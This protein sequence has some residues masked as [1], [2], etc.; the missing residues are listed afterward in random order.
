VRPASQ[1]S[2]AMPRALPGKM[3]HSQRS[4]AKMRSSSAAIL[5]L[6]TLS[7]SVNWSSATCCPSPSKTI[8]LPFSQTMTCTGIP[9]SAQP[10]GGMN[11]PELVSRAPH[12]R[13]TRSIPL[14]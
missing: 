8:T 6:T 3:R 4:R 7:S 5:P 9:G 1:C 2:V 12:I 14:P 11:L 10:P 13:Q